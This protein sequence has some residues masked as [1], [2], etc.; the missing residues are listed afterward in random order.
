MSERPRY[1]TFRDY[2]RVVRERR[3]L[4]GVLTL[5]FTGS[6]VFYVA[7]QAPVY[8]T[9]ASLEFRD[10]N[11]ETS[12][13]GAVTYTAETPEQRAAL[14]AE[15]VLRLEVA[16]RAK[17]ILRSPLTARALLGFIRARPEAGTHLVVVEGRAG[18]VDEAVRLTNAF[19]QATREAE[20]R[21]VRE[22]YA[23]AARAQ[24]QVLRS[25]GRRSIEDFSESFLR[26]H[27]AQLDQIA[28]IIDPVAIRQAAIPPGRQIQ[29]KA[30]TPLLGLLFGLT[31][32][33][34]AAFVRDSLDRRFRSS[35][36]ITEELHLPLLGVVREDTL[37][38][39]L[40]DNR[41]RALS[42]AEV[43][44][45]H[46]MR[47]NVEFLDS[48]SPPKVTIVTSALPEEGKSTIATGLAAAYASAGRSTLLVECD[49]QRPSLAE[50]VKLAA[51]PGLADYLAGR[52]GPS[53]VLQ[54]VQIPTPS[55]PNGDAPGTP[56]PMPLVC[57]TA[58]SAPAQSAEL[59]RSRRCRQFFEQVRDA[60]D[61]VIIDTSPL[62]S[63]ADSL[64]LLPIADAV[65]VCVRMS[66]TTRD[67]ARAA[68]STLAHFPEH[69]MGVVVTGVRARDDDVGYYS[70][71]SADA[72]AEREA[73]GAAH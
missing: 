40:S 18:T 45:F 63:V 4:V 47:T 41:R 55:T 44:R 22:R 29:P 71:D 24:R 64:E 20:R 16:E 21:R 61:V 14:G 1:V 17:R 52:A 59:L 36:E 2:L 56:L 31:F 32:G 37:G 68:K 66:Q 23:E 8:A 43:E 10:V 65:V 48:E 9:E 35:R 27:V 33:L 42:E 62:L 11:V 50:R 25:L 54:L 30:S 60:Y 38:R 26:Q 57:I 7:Q 51:G 46:I 13:L 72:R 3:L 5:L 39:S 53:D 58:G 69:P 28:R 49:L 12:I 67:Q 34:V 15:S 70:Y 73:E 6:A 19:A